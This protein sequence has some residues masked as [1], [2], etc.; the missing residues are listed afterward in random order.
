MAEYTQE[1]RLLAINSPLGKDVLLLTGLSGREE[2]SRPFNFQLDLLSEKSDI[3][4]ADIV[5]KS[6]TFSVYPGQDAARH[7]NGFVARFSAGGLQIR[8][9]RLYRAE[10]V[11]W[12]WFLGQTADCRIFQNKSVP[13]IIEQVFKD[14]G[15]SDYKI[16]VNMDAHPKRDYCVQYRES[17]FQFVSRL[18]EEEGV[19]YFFRHEDGKHTLVID[20]QKSAYKD[21][22]EK[23]VQ[24]FIGSL[25]E[26]HVTE[27]DH[28]YEFRPG[29]FAQTDYNFETPST[30]L[31]TNTSTLIKLPNVDQFEVYD[32]PGEYAK[33]S[34]GEKLIK[35][36]MEE[37]EASHDV[38]RGASN[39][40]SFCPGG[41]FTMK[42]HPCPSEAG[43]GYVIT[44][45]QHSAS[46]SSY[47]Q[48][49]GDDQEY[50]NSFSCI[51]DSV[52]FRP[53]RSTPKPTVRG[54]QT[55]VVVGPPGEEVHTD[56]YSRVKVQF[57]WD[58]EGKRD[59]NSSCWVRVSQSYAGQGWG[60][61]CIPRI[62]Q[63]VIV[64]FLEGDPDQPIITGRVYN[65]EQMPPFKLP[66]DKVVTGIKSNSSPGGGGNNSISMNDTKGKET[67]DVH[68]QK[69]L[70]TTVEN[71]ETHIVVGGYQGVT[72]KGDASL[73][74]Q[75]GNRPVSVDSGTYSVEAAKAVVLHGKSEGVGIEGNAEGVGIKGTGKGVGIEGTGEG[76]GIKGDPVV[77]VEGT[78]EI[79]LTSPF[80]GI[81]DNEV[82]VDAKKI[83]LQAPGGSIT[84]DGSGITING[85]KIVSAAQG[86]HDI[87]GAL[88][89]IN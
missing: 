81:G 32:Y 30:S 18:M 22:P 87:T 29:K 11:P 33:K 12:L 48:G 57:H 64:D 8:D 77:G 39:C 49:G 43:K 51:P 26:S 86:T 38:V 34:D 50:K 3:A 63:E 9:L 21:C 5:G 23:E 19:F 40:S 89:K 61:M 37:I 16:S 60:S 53:A 17:D 31:M 67:M 47:T 41:K 88:V 66:D 54:V 46:D 58:R 75:S 59:D 20:D 28:H 42:R 56:K 71:N 24:H 79:I 70:N 52:L 15:F 14:A 35:I 10:V 62:G 65:A 4:P 78:S 1:G 82:V 85:A 44:S 27:W 2:M 45:I 83:V 80:V 68:A 73:T 69:D 25:E 7:F 84:I 36:R 76:V 13:E 6:V 72:V 55:A 74:V